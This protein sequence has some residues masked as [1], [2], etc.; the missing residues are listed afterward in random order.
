VPEAIDLDHVAVAVEHH[1]DAFACYG[2]ELAGRWLSS[3]TG[4]GFSP[5]QIGYA[6]GMKVEVLMPA[7]VEVNDFLRRFLDRSGPGPHHLTF[8][9]P[10]LDA[11]LARA[12][13]MGYTPINVDRRDTIWQEAFLHPRAVPGVVVQVAQAS[14]SMWATPAPSG[15]PSPRTTEPATLVHVAHAVADL[16][17]GLRLFAGWLDGVEAAFGTD[18]LLGARW[19]DL[20]WPGPGRLRLMTP[21]SPDSDIAAWLGDRPGRIHHLGFACERPGQVAGAV[22][23]PDGAWEVPPERNLG[24]RLRLF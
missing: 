6:N 22:A 8:K 17:E 9:V 7:Q 16:S 21:T 3:G 24:T 23:Q 1:R 14:G 5:A 11:V 10:D 20:A 4:S 2:G 18:D 15:W 13:S 12:E 19:V